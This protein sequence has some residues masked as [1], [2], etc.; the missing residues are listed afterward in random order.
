MESIKTDLA[1]C[2]LKPESSSA[3]VGGPHVHVY[4]LDR[5]PWQGRKY[6]M[7]GGN[8]LGSSTFSEVNHSAI[9]QNADHRSILVA[10][11]ERLSSTQSVEQ[12]LSRRRANPRATARSIT[13]ATVFRFRR[14]RRDTA[15]IVV[16][17]NQPITCSSMIFM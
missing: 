9:D 1:V 7:V 14:M 13:D 12:S 3:N 4:P 2:I 6:P 10:L 16:S 11:L 5:M 17:D 15:D 8:A